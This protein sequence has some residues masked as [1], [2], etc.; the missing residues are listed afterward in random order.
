VPLQHDEAGGRTVRQ[1]EEPQ[2][3]TAG[4]G[5]LAHRAPEEL[6]HARV[7]EAL[8]A[9]TR[10]PMQIEEVAEARLDLVTP[11]RDRDARVACFAAEATSLALELVTMLGRER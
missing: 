4:V 11:P 10:P 3:D 7:H 1:I 8:L 2:R 9:D 5:D 6:L